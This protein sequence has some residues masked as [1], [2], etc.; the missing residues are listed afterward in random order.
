M[1]EEMQLMMARIAQLSDLSGSE[2]RKIVNEVYADGIV[3]RA[4]A[5][6][7]FKLN[8]QFSA[9]DPE[10]TGRFIEAI[11]DFL[12]VREAPE[13]WVSQDEADWLQAQI[14]RDGHIET[15]GEIDLLLALLRHADS[16]PESLSR[17]TL[18]AISNRIIEDGKASDAMAERMRSVLSAPSGEGSLWVTRHEANVLFRTNDAVSGASNS[19]SWNNV[20]AKGILN[21]LLSAAHPDPIS[22]ADALA[23]E[24]WF[25]DSRAD[26]R[27]FFGRM[28]GAFTSGDWFSSISYSEESAAR[29]RYMARETASKSGRVLTGDEKN[30]FLK[31]L[32]WDKSVNAGE[33]QL[34]ELLKEEAPGFVRGLNEALKPHDA[35]A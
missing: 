14:E 24:A 32:G 16:A 22:E 7:L 20:F 25:K 29:A 27:G 18:K 15:E 8:N 4:E 3:S 21:H 1:N 23:R 13:G 17:F 6:A 28:A 33:R 31:R 19:R 34:I 26:V 12:I 5:E 11:K 9:T 30:W 2:A 10:W 35:A